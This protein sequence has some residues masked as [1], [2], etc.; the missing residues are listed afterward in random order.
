MRWIAMEKMANGPYSE[1]LETCI[2]AREQSPN[3]V[4]AHD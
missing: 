2:N 4:L 3:V 1:N